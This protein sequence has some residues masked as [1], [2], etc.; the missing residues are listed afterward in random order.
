MST[1]LDTTMSQIQQLL[2]RQIERVNQMKLSPP[3]T[4]M[5]NLSNITIGVCP[6]DG[7]GP[8]IATEAQR[9]MQTVLDQLPPPSHR[10]IQFKPIHGLTIE[11]RLSLGVAIPPTVLAD[12]KSCHVILKG[13]TTTPQVGMGVANI[14]SANVAMRRELDLFA[15]VRPVQIPQL[16]IDWTFFR[17]NTEGEY[18]L[19]SQG[20]EV[21]HDISL[22]FKITT[23]LGCERIIRA[24]F[25]FAKQTGKKRVSVVTKSNVIKTTDGRF[26]RV[27]REI[28]EEYKAD[29][30]QSDEW[31]VDIMAAKLIDPARQSDFSV[32]VMPNLY[33]DI[34]TDE[35]AQLQGGVGTAGSANIGNR[36]AMFEAIHGSAPRMV[37]EG[38]GDYADPSSMI[39]AGAMLL[40]HIGLIDQANQIEQALTL[41][42]QIEKKW[43]ITGRSDGVTAS[44]FADYILEWAIH[45]D[46]DTHYS[47]GIAHAS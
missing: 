33:G 46:L 15:N 44:Q 40:R 4:P 12:L 1:P 8:V 29:G 2:N 11:N 23:Q 32:L 43:I 3:N 5:A 19:G 30:I 6:G 21:N 36:W 34:L 35:A 38:R 39:K 7:I 31:Y 10:H 13:P 14:E 18:V 25:E 20:I 28:A 26:S 17:E 42:T 45:P 9:V 41:C 24:A 22:D 27:A 37:S 47:K 16:G